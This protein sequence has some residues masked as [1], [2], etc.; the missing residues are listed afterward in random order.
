MEVIFLTIAHFIVYCVVS[1]IGHVIVTAISYVIYISCTAHRSAMRELTLYKN[2]IIIVTAVS[3]VIVTA[4][5]RVIVTAASHVIVT[6][7]SCHCHCC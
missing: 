5:S 4:V 2:S 3:R 6:A 1:S 7:V